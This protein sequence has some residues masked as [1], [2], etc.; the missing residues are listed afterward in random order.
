MTIKSAFDYTVFSL[1]GTYDRSEATNI[2]RLIF[3]EVFDITNTSK[4]EEFEQKEE[5]ESIINRLK[6]SEPMDYIIG[7]TNFY[8]YEFMVNENV[9]IPRPE[10]EELVKWI[11]DDHKGIH[12][13]LDVLDI[14]SG[15]GCIGI[16]IKKKKPTFRVFSLE[17][18]M[19]AMNC[20]RINA[21]N[22]KANIEFFRTDFLDTSIWEAFGSF[23]IIVSNPPYISISEKELMT[24]NTLSFEPEK[25]LFAPGT[26]P[27]IFYK[28]II[29]FAVDH[30]N[31]DGAIYVELNEFRAKEIQK[32][33]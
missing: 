8:G 26:D 18:D 20:T 22:L 30:L 3:K 1:L 10:T 11:L 24:E 13:Q 4:L 19:D 2:S 29:S 6:H 5:L 12:K 23:D 9:L 27:L 31:P 7:N 25:A 14:G 16:T 21:R 15:S 17:E 28:Y 33:I 32:N